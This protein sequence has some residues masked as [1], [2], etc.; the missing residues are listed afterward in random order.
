MIKTSVYFKD[1]MK[2]VFDADKVVFVPKDI[3]I[4]AFRELLKLGMR[5]V[6]MDNIN[7]AKE[8]NVDDDDE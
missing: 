6:W 5:V 8:E 2:A 1:G 4:E 3:T 7:W